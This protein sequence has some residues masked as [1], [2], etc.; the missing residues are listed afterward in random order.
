MSEARL[1]CIIAF[2][3]HITMFETY[4]NFAYKIEQF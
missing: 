1:I 2:K 4:L 3:L